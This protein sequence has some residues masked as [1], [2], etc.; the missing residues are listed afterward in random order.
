LDASL[1]ALLFSEDG[2][3]RGVGLLDGALRMDAAERIRSLAADGAEFAWS[4]AVEGFG[5]LA[6]R[7]V[8][9]LGHGRPRGL[10][11]KMIKSVK[12]CDAL[13]EMHPQPILKAA[14]VAEATP[15]GRDSLLDREPVALGDRLDVLSAL[16]LGALSFGVRDGLAFVEAVVTGALDRR[17]VEENISPL[18]LD[19]SKTLVRQ[20][21]DR[22]L[23]HFVNSP[24]RIKW[25]E[26]TAAP[27]CKPAGGRAKQKVLRETFR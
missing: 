27:S 3:S 11:G 24:A 6:R 23:R 9:L 21:F 2:L 12:G 18:A 13:T 5:L 22:S 25:V 26:R 4:L 8:E 19:E 7:G 1:L 14:G 16:A 20:L 17:R 10:N 15:R